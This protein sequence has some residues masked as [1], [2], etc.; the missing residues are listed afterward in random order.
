MVWRGCDELLDHNILTVVTFL[1]LLGAISAGFLPAPRSRHPLVCPGSLARHAAG[2]AAPAVVLRPRSGGFQFDRTSPGF[3]HPNIHYHLGVDGISLWL[4]VLTTFLMPLCVL[5]SWKS[6]N[7]QVKEFFVLMLVLET[8]M[9]GVFIALDLFLFYFF[10][11]ATL[12]PMALIIGMY[13]HG[14]NDLRRREVFPVHDDR[15]G[16]HAGGRHL[17][18]HAHRQLRLRRD[19][20]QD[21]GRAGRG[22]A[23]AG[24][25]LFL[26]F[27]VAFAVKV[28]LF[29][30]HTWLPDAHVEAPTAGSVLLAGVLL[31]MGTYGLLRFNVGLFPDQA[32]RNAPWIM[33][34]AIIGIVYGALVAMVQP[35]IKRLIAYTSVSHLG[36]V[37]LGIFSFTQLGV[38][39]AVYQ[40]LNHG[41]STGA[42]FM[43]LGMIYDRRHTY[44]ISEY[45]G[46]ATP[47]PIYATFFTFI[48]LSSVG[49]PLLNGFVGEFLV[50]SGAFQ[51]RQIYGIL[52]A[53]GVIWSGCYL[54][55]MYQ[56]VF[57]GEVTNPVNTKLRDLDAREQLSLWPLV[58]A[59]LVMGVAPKL[60]LHSIDPSVSAALKQFSSAT[61]AASTAGL[62]V[63]KRLHKGDRTM[64]P[65]VDYIRILPEL[66]VSIFGIICML[67]DPLLP[68]QSPKKQLGIIAVIGT[69]AGLAATAYQ[70][71]FYGSAFYNTMQRRHLQRLL[72]RRC[73][74]DCAGRHPDLVRVSG[75]TAHPFRRILQLDSVRYRRHDADVGCRRTRPCL[76]RSR[77]LV[78]LHLHSCRHASPRGGKCRG[79]AEVFPAWFVC[80]GILPVW[81]RLVFGATGTTNVYGIA[82]YLQGQP[83]TLAYLAVGLMFVGLAFKVGSA[84][85]HVWTPDVY[86]GSPAPVVALMSTGPKAAAFAVL[87]RVLFATNAPGWFWMVWVS[88]VLSMTLGNIG[89]LVQ[90][91]VKRLLAYSSIAHAGYILVAF[92]A[93]KQLGISAAIF[94]AASYAA[95]NV[96]A[97]AVVSH[98]ASAGEKYVT[99]DDYSGL[100]R[101]SPLWQRF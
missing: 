23:H 75:R 74:V 81:R 49:L 31:K 64:I 28:P 16:I 34:L 1:P 63:I 96:G 15:V 55:W 79:V 89:A 32:R 47:M 54:L 60:W 71:N 20:K 98:F 87:L 21:P 12:I 18:V 13:G 69:L 77:N 29:P 17:A 43:L 6:I 42:L 83:S 86:E 45:G 70:T 10:W 90:Q 35:N 59:A 56:R 85:F 37:V 92:A 48:M 99:L 68:E 95:M 62:H 76:H 36:F 61:Q 82:K 30:V 67:V 11:E 94:Y 78:H 58:V 41:V 24:I 9:I 19:P 66:V 57:Y 51:A 93:A 46:L 4:V 72:S 8:A 44:E 101:R 25:W 80:Y 84:P 73:P 33:V 3:S 88:A 39:G 27:F 50:L 2:L 52:A 14:R 26:G 100:G 97:F 22:F 65:A 91:N 40:M 38:D 7:H 5:I 53:T